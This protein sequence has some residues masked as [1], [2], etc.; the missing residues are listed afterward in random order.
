MREGHGR[1][2]P[3]PRTLDPQGPT[4]EQSLQLPGW[5]GRREEQ[6]VMECPRKTAPSLSLVRIRKL[7]SRDGKESVQGRTA[8][9]WQ[10]QGLNPG[11]TGFWAL[12]AVRTAPPPLWGAQR[13]CP[14][15]CALHHTSAAAPGCCSCACPHFPDRD[16]GAQRGTVT[17]P[18]SHSPS[19]VETGLTFRNY[20]PLPRGCSAARMACCL[21]T[22]C[23]DASAD[24]HRPGRKSR[25]CLPRVA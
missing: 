3:R 1:L 22:A 18:E 5:P 25:L 4:P 17:F 10:S 6:A 14:A 9:T 11:F 13:T 12:V 24:P 20:P 16:S 7:E 19:V 8:R 15:S 23:T 2:L 21:H